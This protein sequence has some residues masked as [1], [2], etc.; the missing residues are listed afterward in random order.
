MHEP[1]FDDVLEARK[2]IAAYLQPTPFHEV[3]VL[4]ERIGCRYFLKFESMQPIGAFKV[5]GGVNLVSRLGPEEKQAGLITASTGNHG[6]SIAYAARI[7]GVKALIAAPNGANPDKISAIERLGAE[8]AFAGKDFDDA[9]MW[10]EEQCE[11]RGM[12]YVHSA[13]EPRLI[14]GVATQTLEIMESEPDIEVLIVPLGGGSGV[15][16]AGL[17][18]KHM[19]PKIHVVGVQAEKAPAFYK[20]F[21]AGEMQPQPSADTFADGLATRV[22]YEL[23]FSM[24]RRYVDEI[25]TVSEEEMCDAIRLLVSDVHVIAEGAGAAPTAAAM[26]MDL[27]DKRVA[28][29]LS[30]RNLTSEHLGIILNGGTP[31]P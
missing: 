21:Y 2:R 31:R 25:V 30:G 18:A 7:F 4:S 26:K 9:R 17:V 13:N 16:G 24:I 19:N 12:R 15:C 28:A 20:S 1:V 8:V 27:K 23:T 29:I 3:P 5:R 6:Q 22:P 10:C 14:A 11:E